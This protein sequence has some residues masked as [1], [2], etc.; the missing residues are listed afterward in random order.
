MLIDIL[1]V[2]YGDQREFCY[3]PYDKLKVGD[4]VETAWGIGRVEMMRTTLKENDEFAYYMKS[5]DAKPVLSLQMD[6]GD[7]DDGKDLSEE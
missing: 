5:T 4:L 7:E 3:A 1:V 6:Y 2:D